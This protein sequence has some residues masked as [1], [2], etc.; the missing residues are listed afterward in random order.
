MTDPKPRRASEPVRLLD[1]PIDPDAFRLARE[2]AALLVAR[3]R[4]AS[5]AE[6]DAHMRA[7]LREILA[8]CRRVRLDDDPEAAALMQRA[9]EFIDTGDPS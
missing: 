6:L 8:V 7:M 1:A 3:Q 4:S 5:A 2:R 9:A